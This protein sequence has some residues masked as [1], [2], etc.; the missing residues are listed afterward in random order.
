MLVGL[1]TCVTYRQVPLTD[2]FYLVKCDHCEGYFYVEKTLPE[3]ILTD[4]HCPYCDFTDD[5]IIFS[6][7]VCED[8]IVN[9]HSTNDVLKS[10]LAYFYGYTEKEATQSTSEQ[11]MFIDELND[12][13]LRQDDC[14]RFVKEQKIHVEMMVNDFMAEEFESEINED[15]Y[16]KYYSIKDVCPHN[17]F[18][19]VNAICCDLDFKY[20]LG[21]ETHEVHCPYCG[22][23]FELIDD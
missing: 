22:G 23:V 8:L 20:R 7:K 17:D 9:D 1:K 5:M 2:G 13:E 10:N 18:K 14:E 16:I 19:V 11:A 6:L 12:Y 3:D 21:E 15:D 4:I